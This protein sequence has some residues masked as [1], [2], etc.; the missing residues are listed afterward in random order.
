MGLNEIPVADAVLEMLVRTA[1]NANVGELV[2]VAKKLRLII[3]N[4][5]R[6]AE[7]ALIVKLRRIGYAQAAEELEGKQNDSEHD[8]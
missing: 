6:R 4:E 7:K 8:Q 2:D 5:R 1:P 3:E